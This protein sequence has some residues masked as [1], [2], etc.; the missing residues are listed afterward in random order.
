MKVVVQRVSE[1][2]VVV[3]ERIVGSIKKGYLVY[4]GIAKDDNT[5]VALKMVAKINALRIFEDDNE[6]MNLS[7]KQVSGEILVISQFTLLGETK[8]NNRPSFTNAAN[9]DKAKNLYNIFIEEL[10]STNLV[11]TGVFGQHMKVASINDGPVT[12]LI[13]M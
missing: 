6:K 2:K 10:S 5:E 9:P 13:E 1:A 3:Q 8:G 4:L 7:L 12:I 11:E